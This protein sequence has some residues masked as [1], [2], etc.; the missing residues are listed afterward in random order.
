MR[1]SK[2]ASSAVVVANRFVGQ[3]GR[4]RCRRERLLGLTLRFH[5]RAEIR[6]GNLAVGIDRPGSC[7]FP[8]QSG[9]P[10]A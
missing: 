10:P 7:I 9:L 8:T 2:L 3:R 4:V 6:H 5:R 1:A